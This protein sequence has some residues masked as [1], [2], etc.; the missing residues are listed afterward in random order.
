MVFK[1]ILIFVVFAI[2]M[3]NSI[4]IKKTIEEEKEDEEVAKAVNRTLA[5]EE[6]KRKEEEDEKKKDTV[7]KDSGEKKKD[8]GSQDEACPPVNSSC[9]TVKLCPPCHECPE[10]VEEDCPPM[11][12]CLAQEVCPEV[13]P[14]KPC[15]PCPP[16]HCQPC[17]VANCTS[18]D[19]TTVQPPS[20]AGCPEASMTVPMAM[21]VGAVASLFVTGVA[22]TIGLLL[23]Y[24]SPIVSGFL[25]LAVTIIIWY[26][27]SQY[28]ETARELGGRAAT[29]LRE[30]AVALSHRVMEALRHRNEQVGFSIIPTSLD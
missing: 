7:K 9:P 15:G 22:A 29:L 11:K 5:E 3:E 19:N 16:I 17:P 14:C 23:R 6:K 1:T 21:V 13:E 12:E 25:F 26:L 2:L 4:S 28:P 20:T 10:L 18:V 8:R 27:S 30:A 24:V